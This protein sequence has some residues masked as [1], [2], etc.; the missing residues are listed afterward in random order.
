MHLLLCSKMQKDL[1]GKKRKQNVI[2]REKNLVNPYLEGKMW[3]GILI[4]FLFLFL[5]SKN[6]AACE[7]WGLWRTENVA[8]SL[9]VI[10][11]Q[12]HVYPCE[13]QKKKQFLIV[14]A[15]EFLYLWSEISFF[16]VPCY[17]LFSIYLFTY[18][19]GE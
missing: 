4:S 11:P 7:K 8:K 2:R 6:V 12:F 19:L 18:L 5:F 17:L 1:E 9:F 15:L 3:S 16:P 14:R 10:N 13:K